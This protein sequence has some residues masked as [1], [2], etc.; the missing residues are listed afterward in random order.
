MAIPIVYQ[1]FRTWLASARINFERTL[2]MFNNNNK[3]NNNHPLQEGN[4]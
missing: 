1:F 4:S 3:D 2:K